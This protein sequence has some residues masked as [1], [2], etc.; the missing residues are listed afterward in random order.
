M[1]RAVSRLLN[2]TTPSTSSY[3]PVR[4]YFSTMAS[5]PPRGRGPANRSRGRARGGFNPTRQPQQVS[6]LSTLPSASSTPQLSGATTPAELE[7]NSTTKTRFADVPGLDP[8]LINAL[9]FEFCT[10]VS[11]SPLIVFPTL[12]LFRYKQQP[13]PLYYKVMIS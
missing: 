13:Y 10:E 9:P 8:K 7:P 11:L 4:T 12:I 5:L 6:H 2:N 1:L 3:L